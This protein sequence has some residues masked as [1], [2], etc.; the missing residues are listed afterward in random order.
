[1]L[2]VL[3]LDYQTEAARQEIKNIRV[4][5]LLKGYLFFLIKL[6]EI[7]GYKIDEDLAQNNL[8]KKGILQRTVRI[9]SR[10]T[11][12]ITV[13]KKINEPHPYKMRSNDSKFSI[14]LFILT[15]LNGCFWGFFS[16]RLGFLQNTKMS[17]NF[18]HICDQSSS[19]SDC[20][21]LWLVVSW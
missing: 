20:Y 7:S 15:K 18:C 14:C 17:Q 2:P 11:K 3:N 16:R 9:C 5:F 4:P 6:K 12:E 21:L 10:N 19:S 1:M 13:V 8:R